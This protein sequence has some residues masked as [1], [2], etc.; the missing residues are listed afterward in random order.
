MRSE[1]Y[2]RKRCVLVLNVIRINTFSFILCRACAA[3]QLTT[4]AR[5][6]AG[7]YDKVKDTIGKSIN[8]FGGFNITQG[9]LFATEQQRV[10]EDRQI[11]YN[12]I[13]QMGNM[14]IGTQGMIEWQR[15]KFEAEELENKDDDEYEESNGK[16]KKKHKKVVDGANV[17]MPMEVDQIFKS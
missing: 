11:L 2:S 14:S 12:V 15:M 6:C 1:F 10:Q 17:P 7:S 16:R 4:I 8:Y 3:P 9:D 5:Y 13:Q